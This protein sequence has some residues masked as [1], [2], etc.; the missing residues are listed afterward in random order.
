ME[1]ESC[2]ARVVAAVIDLSSE[3]LLVTVGATE[4]LQASEHLP[5]YILPRDLLLPQEHHGLVDVPVLVT[6]MLRN[7]VA[8][9]VDEE[10]RLWTLDPLALIARVQ[11]AT[12]DAP[13]QHV[14]LLLKQVLQLLHEQLALE[15]VLLIMQVIEIPK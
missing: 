3:E 15:L 7:R 10:I 5:E 6:L 11:G 8:V 12:V 1:V 9:V 4:L 14:V 2:L 13:L